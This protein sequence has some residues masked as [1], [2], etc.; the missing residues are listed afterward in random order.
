M[1]DIT[2]K[3]LC[4]VFPYYLTVREV[5]NNIRARK[6]VMNPEVS[7]FLICYWLSLHLIDTIQKTIISKAGFFEI[8]PL[9]Y[10]ASICF[11]TI[12]VWLLYSHGC[13]VI[14]EV[15]VPGQLRKIVTCDK[16]VSLTQ[17]FENR[18]LEPLAK[19][20]TSSTS[21]ERLI[22]LLEKAPENIKELSYIKSALQMRERLNEAIYNKKPI[23]D[24]ISQSLCYLDSEETV[25]QIYKNVRPIERKIE[26]LIVAV[27][28]YAGLCSKGMVNKDQQVQIADG[29][30]S[31]LH[32][33]IMKTEIPDMA[34]SPCISTRSLI[35]RS[36]AR[37]YQKERKSHANHFRSPLQ[38][39]GNNLSLG[40][41]KPSLADS[42][43]FRKIYHE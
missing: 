40:R 10:L 34:S 14:C 31:C 35:K 27:I 28:R 6:R 38:D 22:H 37:E 5:S 18:Y 8:Y 20:C 4:Y 12:K 19:Y 39:V 24:H 21:L 42:K 30:G 41:V 29:A 17:N 9:S 7:T 13:L 11:S 26:G 43:I 15:I 16:S 3:I 32:K 1:I 25:S 33:H 36:K 23:V 2:I